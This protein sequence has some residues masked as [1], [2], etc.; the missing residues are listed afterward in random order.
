M[1]NDQLGIDVASSIANAAAAFAS[2]FGFVIRYYSHNPS[3]NLT[4]SELQALLGAGLKV[5]VVWETLGNHAGYFSTSQ[6]ATDSADALGM[7]N[8]LGQ[9]KG[10]AIY[11]A[12]DFDATPSDIANLVTPY[13]K[14][15]HSAFENAGMPYFVGVY[16]SGATCAALS[17][18]GVVHHTWLAQSTGWSGYSTYQNYDMKQGASIT[19]HG[20]A[21]DPD[22]IRLG[23]NPG[24][25]PA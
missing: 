3:K 6:G 18:A 12:V 21:C 1:S 17:A 5:G 22:T 20:F 16:G 7:A 11:F 25:F 10:S 23:G 9:N 2:D 4:E 15:V 19:A 13:F 24:L 8:A 14:A